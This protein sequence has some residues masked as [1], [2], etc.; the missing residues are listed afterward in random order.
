MVTVGAFTYSDLDEYVQQWGLIP[1]QAWRFGGLT[2]LTSF[3]LHAG[4]IHLIGNAY[5]LII[6]GDNVEDYLGRLRYLALLVL[7]SLLGDGLH[8]L[9]EPR[10]EMPCIGASGG[11]SGIIVYY[12]LQFPRARLGIILG[13]WYFFRW[14]YFPAYFALVCWLGL[15]GLI[16]YFQVS[17]LSNVSALAHLGGA[18]VGVGAW[19]LWHNR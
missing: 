16:A 6:F 5:F 12:A 11:I 7:A 18:G 4:P 3:F 14:F 8:I 13:C 9:L 17:G 2:F 1:A 19:L 10:S 15:Q